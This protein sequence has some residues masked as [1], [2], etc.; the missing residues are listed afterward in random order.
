[1]KMSS[2]LFEKNLQRTNEKRTMLIAK[3]ARVGPLCVGN[4]YDVMRRCGNPY[5]HCAKKPGHKQTLLIY[6]QK[7]RR[8]CKL[9][10]RKDEERIKQAWQNY[11]LFRQA[12]RELRA[13]NKRELSNLMAEIENRRLYY[14]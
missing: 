7:G 8:Y 1:M 5:C 14:K 12:L 4:V 3:L 13:I 10:R 2:V 9:V 6:T 11:R